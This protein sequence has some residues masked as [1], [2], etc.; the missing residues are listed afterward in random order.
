[1]F[2]R[3]RPPVCFAVSALI[4]PTVADHVG[5]VHGARRNTHCLRD[6]GLRHSTLAQQHHLNALVRDISGRFRTAQRALETIDQSLDVCGTGVRDRPYF[7][8]KPKASG[9]G[10]AAD[11]A[12]SPGIPLGRRARLVWT[13]GRTRGL[14]D[15]PMQGQIRKLK[16]AQ[17]WKIPAVQPRSL[18]GCGVRRSL[19]A[20]SP[21]LQSVRVGPHTL[22]LSRARPASGGTSSIFIT[23]EMGPSI[24]IAD[25]GHSRTR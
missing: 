24:E 18:R 6:R 23:C 13:R 17:R 10:S 1:M 2:S 15:P 22:R 9:P 4:P 11:G 16:T 5:A 19:G 7:F 14:F 21:L 3:R 20:A 12:Q 8:P 25:R